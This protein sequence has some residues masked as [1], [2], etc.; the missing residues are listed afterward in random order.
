VNVTG[1][2]GTGTFDADFTTTVGD[3]LAVLPTSAVAATLVAAEIV[4]GIGGSVA[5]PPPHPNTAIDVADTKKVIRARMRA[6]VGPGVII[7]TMASEWIDFGSGAEA[8]N[9][10]VAGTWRYCDGIAKGRRSDG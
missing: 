8:S 6:I 5:S 1:T 3:V 4:A 10:T 2:P 9:V 7:I